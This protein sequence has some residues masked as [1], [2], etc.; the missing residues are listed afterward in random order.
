MSKSPI[1]SNMEATAERKK[2]SVEPDSGWVDINLSQL[3]QRG[4]ERDTNK[5]K[6]GL[7]VVI[8]VRIT[9]F[10]AAIIIIIYFVKKA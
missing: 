1:L 9:Q 8:I 10:I 6:T 5:H 2:L 7:G 3:E 4:Q